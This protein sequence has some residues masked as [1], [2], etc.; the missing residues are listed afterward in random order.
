MCGEPGLEEGASSSL[1]G[2]PILPEVPPEPAEP[3]PIPQEVGVEIPPGVDIQAVVDGNPEGTTFLIKAGI[4]RR[5][6]VRPKDGMTFVGEAGA[7]LDGEGDVRFAFVG[8][9]TSSSSASNNVTIRNLEIRNYDSPIQYGAIKAADVDIA[10]SG[11]GWV[12]EDCDIHRNSG[13]G[14]RTGHRMV[15][16]GNYIHHNGQIGIVGQG[17]DILVEDNEIAFNNTRNLRITDGTLGEY[18]G[19]KFVKTRNLIVRN[20]YVHDNTEHGLW[21]DIDNVDTL[22]EGNRVVDNTGAGIFFEISYGAVIRNNYVEGNASVR[23]SIW[24]YSGIFVSSSRDVEI[25]GNTL[26]D[27]WNGITALSQQRGSGV[28]GVHEVRNLYVHD[29][30]I[31]IQKGLTG[32]GQDVGDNSFFT[33]KNNRFQNNTYT[34]GSNSRYF[35]WMNK[36]RSLEGWNSFGQD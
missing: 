10:R 26:V 33:G 29:N 21:V 35:H 20:N 3:T 5:Q 2:S 30:M 7:V 24:H 36:R 23:G 28:L 14:I 34:L 18:G 9:R 15:I 4:H 12:I 1:P 16:R 32:L 27:N 8:Y 6:S 13:G 31:T 17:D 22:I 19:T 25:Y 11:T